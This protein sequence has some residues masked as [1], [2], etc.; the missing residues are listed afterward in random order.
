MKALLL[1]AAA[2]S[3]LGISFAYADGEV[4]PANTMFT[5]F[6]GVLAH[7]P[8]AVASA[9]NEQGVDDYAT[10]S[11]RDTWAFPPNPNGGDNQ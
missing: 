10:Q 2:V 1:A 3:G 8:H 6:P 9:S 5:Q 7:A 11:T 4:P